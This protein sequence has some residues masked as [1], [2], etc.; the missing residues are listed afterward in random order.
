MQSILYMPWQKQ[1]GSSRNVQKGVL[2]GQRELPKQN[3][4]INLLQQF[5]FSKQKGHLVVR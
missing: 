4:A 2:F 5:F 1:K 3:T